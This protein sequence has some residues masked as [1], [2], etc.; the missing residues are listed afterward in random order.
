MTMTVMFSPRGSVSG[1]SDGAPESVCTTLT[2][3]MRPRYGLR[4]LA[5]ISSVISS[6]RAAMSI[7]DCEAVVAL[8]PQ[9]SQLMRMRSTSEV[10]LAIPLSALCS[11]FSRAAAVRNKKR[12]TVM[13][14]PSRTLVRRKTVAKRSVP[15]MQP[16]AARGPRGL[17]A[18]GL[19]VSIYTFRLCCLPLRLLSLPLF[20]F[21][22][23]SLPSRPNAIDE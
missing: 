9:S 22:P 19:V 6:V 15:S 12:R 1:G 10:V 4:T 13:P 18:D 8:M 14:T 7:S 17:R 5:L 21:Y 23:L 16:R 3:S 2:S 20:S 11:T